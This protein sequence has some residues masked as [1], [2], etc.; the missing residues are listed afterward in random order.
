[1]E[2][3]SVKDSLPGTDQT[4]VLV[5]RSDREPTIAYFITTETYYYFCIGNDTKQTWKPEFWLPI[6]KP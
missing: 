3:I 2:W 5:Y 6:T 1:M 4:L